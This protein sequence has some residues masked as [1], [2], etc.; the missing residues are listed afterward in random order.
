MPHRLATEH[1]GP[2]LVTADNTSSADQIEP[3]LPGDDR[4][5]LLITS[6]DVPHPLP[7]RRLELAVPSAA[8]SVALL[9]GQLRIHNPAA[10]RITATP[11]A[12]ARVAELCAG[13]PLALRVAA[14]LLVRDPGMTASELAGE[15]ARSRLGCTGR[16]P[17][18]GTRLLR[19]VV[20]APLPHPSPGVRVARSGA[21]T[22][23][24]RPPQR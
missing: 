5:L 10:S 11:A 2:I 7:G 8:S 13:L 1:G 12:L 15:L 20:P 16:R 18:R 19:A 6:R 4:G 9:V 21:R 24:R 14:A 23:R 17:P 22:E 3:L